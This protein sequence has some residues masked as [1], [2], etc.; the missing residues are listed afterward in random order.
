MD[1][2]QY[3]E[4]VKSLMKM[5]EEF[6]SIVVSVY[7]NMWYQKSNYTYNTK[8]HLFLFRRHLFDF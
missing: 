1:S 4:V 7:L 6:T 8:A 5:K 3:E 2:L